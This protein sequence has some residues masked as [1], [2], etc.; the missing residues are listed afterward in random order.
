MG[1]VWF[2]QPERRWDPG[3]RGGWGRAASGAPAPALRAV[4]QVSR[5]GPRLPKAPKTTT[6]PLRLLVYGQ[7]Q[8]EQ[9]CELTGVWLRGRPS[10]SAPQAEA[11]PPE[12]RRV[13]EELGVR[14]ARPA[15]TLH[16]SADAL[17][18]HRG[19]CGGSGKACVA[20]LSPTRSRGRSKPV[21][22]RVS[23]DRPGRLQPP[24]TPRRL[25]PRIPSP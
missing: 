1:R 4:A 9:P 7:A 25:P 2:T 19:A 13:P 12:P 24:R 17:W 6:P 18:G 22:A 5:A 11:S 3:P 23:S 8:T 14:G 21:T 10:P 15:H 20:A 16:L